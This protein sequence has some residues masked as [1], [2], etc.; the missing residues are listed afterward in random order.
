MSEP[1]SVFYR[2]IDLTHVDDPPKLLIVNL[3]DDGDHNDQC[4]IGYEPVEDGKTYYQPPC[5]HIICESCIKDNR[6][7]VCGRCAQDFI[8]AEPVRVLI[9]NHTIIID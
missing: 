3:D 5:G 7:R 8:V 4:C 2:I 1:N 9:K 6:V